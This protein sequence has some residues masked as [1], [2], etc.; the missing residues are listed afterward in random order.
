MKR[1]IILSGS[2][3]LLMTVVV[4]I[5]WDLFFSK[6]EDRINPYAYDLNSL[7]SG[8]TS[9]VMY[10]E[11]QQIKPGMSGIQG[12]ATDRTDHIY[13]AGENGVEVFDQ[14]GKRFAVFP[15]EGAAR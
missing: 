2:L 6:T 5:G 10:E 14:T 3:V 8:D 9:L 15:I 12:I 1:K 4:L 11:T 7:K 13:V